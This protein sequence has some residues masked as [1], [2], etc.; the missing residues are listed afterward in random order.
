MQRHNVWMRKLR[1]RLGLAPEAFE[2]GLG[3]DHVGRQHLYGEVALEHEIFYQKHD[4]K[5]A[6]AKWAIND[7]AVT[8][9]GRELFFKFGGVGHA[10]M[11]GQKRAR[12]QSA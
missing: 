7:V 9:G 8:Q 4:R 10:R 2:H 6:F 5:A 3:S 1:D 12:R 11:M